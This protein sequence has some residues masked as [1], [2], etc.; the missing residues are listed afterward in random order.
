MQR[1]GAMLGNR[2]LQ[3]SLGLC[4][5]KHPRGDVHVAWLSPGCLQ[6]ISEITLA[7]KAL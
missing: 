5:V 4:P 2:V 1:S 7:R 6:V 3:P